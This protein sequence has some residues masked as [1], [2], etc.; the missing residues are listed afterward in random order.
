MCCVPRC[1]MPAHTRYAAIV[2]PGAQGEVTQVL[3]ALQGHGD[4]HAIAFR[5][6]A[7]MPQ[8]ISDPNSGNAFQ[9]YI[10]PSLLVQ[11]GEPGLA[12][13][14]LR[15]WAYTDVAG[16]SEW[17]VMMPAIGQ[18]RCDPEFVALVKKIKTTDPHYAKLC[19][20]KP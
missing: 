14:N 3:D 16:Q 1:C 19:A 8:S 18:L 20:G 9:P 6:A 4:R 12:L 10:I 17:A 15:A 11:L 5:L 2:N 13:K 7:F